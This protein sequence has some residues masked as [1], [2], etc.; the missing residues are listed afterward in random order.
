VGSMTSRPGAGESGGPARRARSRTRLRGP[1]V[2]VGAALALA[3]SLGTATAAPSPA[4]PGS[5]ERSGRSADGVWKVD[6]YGT[7]ITIRDGVL[8]TWDTTSIS[9]LPR[10]TARQQ[11]APGPGGV[12]FGSPEGEVTVRPHSAGRASLQ[13]HGSVGVR[14]LHRIAELPEQCAR[15]APDG[16]VAAFDIFWQTFAENYAFFDERGMDWGAVREKYRPRVH[17]GT[18]DSELF[19]ILS[20]MVKPL[21]DAH[22]V[23]EADTPGFS[24][25]AHFMRPGTVMPTQEYDEETRKFIERRNLGGQALTQYARGA[26]G[27]ADL[28]GGLGYL[29]ISRFGGYTPGEAAY[30]S[31]AAELDRALDHIITRARASGPDAW[32]GLI[33]DVRVNGGGMDALGLDI[34]A[35]L[36]DRAYT[37][38]AKQARNDPGDASRFTRRQSIRVTPAAGVPRYTG[39]VAVLTGGAAV[40]A[41]ETFTQALDGRPGPTTRIGENTQGVFSDVLDRALPNGWLFGLTNEKYTDPRG[42]TYEGPGL[43]PHLR[44]PVFTEEEFAADRDSAFD[45]ARSLLGRR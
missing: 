5:A 29:R 37:A 38:Y 7:A 42:H 30:A 11:G 10:M 27:Y 34:A 3:G 19:D 24:R 32:R 13:A 18:S 14:H 15:P 16:P 33:I 8:R 6:G 31:D 43:P 28:P 20:E 26:L 9:C 17:A 22:V 23:L 40:S 36:T 41:G 39:P 25:F 35:R 21:G 1:L 45:R 44:T 2:A 4:G 12:R